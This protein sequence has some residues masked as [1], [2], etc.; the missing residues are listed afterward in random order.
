MFSLGAA[1]FRGRDQCLIALVSGVTLPR[2]TMGTYSLDHQTAKRMRKKDN[3][4][5]G[6]FPNLYCY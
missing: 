6:R 4:A 5:F 1:D 2:Y 3:R